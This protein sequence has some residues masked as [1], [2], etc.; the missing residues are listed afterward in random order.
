MANNRTT[1]TR[2]VSM[3]DEAWEILKALAA[4]DLRAQNAEMEFLIRS[5]AADRAAIVERANA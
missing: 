4:Q 5:A 1:V 3:S 2:S